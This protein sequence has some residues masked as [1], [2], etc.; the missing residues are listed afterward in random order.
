MYNVVDRLYARY[1]VESKSGD[2]C[3][4]EAGNRAHLICETGYTCLDMCHSY[5][6]ARG[7]VHSHVFSCCMSK[8]KDPELYR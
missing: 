1:G 7:Y 6:L 4:L 8:A 5:S 3:L 2:G